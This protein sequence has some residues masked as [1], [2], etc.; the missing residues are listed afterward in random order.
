M[1]RDVANGNT[2]ELDAIAGPIIRGAQKHGIVLE[3][4]PRLVSDIGA[5]SPVSS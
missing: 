5:A 4:T 1:E 3:A 2:P